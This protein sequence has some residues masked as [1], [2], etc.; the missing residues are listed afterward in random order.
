[1]NPVAPIVSQERRT[2]STGKK[3]FRCHL[4]GIVYLRGQLEV[5]PADKSDDFKYRGNFVV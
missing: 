5:G 2:A 1:M 3:D 4:V